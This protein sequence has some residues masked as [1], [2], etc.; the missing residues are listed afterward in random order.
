MKKMISLTNLLTLGNN[1]IVSSPF[2][3]IAVLGWFKLSDS[4]CPLQF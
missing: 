2:K 4:P 1:Y 3:A